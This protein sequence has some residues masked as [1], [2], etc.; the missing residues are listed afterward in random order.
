MSGKM[1]DLQLWRVEIWRRALIRAALAQ[2][3]I[4]G[5]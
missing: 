5:K 3:T 1:T 4:E 2:R